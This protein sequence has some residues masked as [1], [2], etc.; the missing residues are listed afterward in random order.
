[1]QF[2]RSLETPV[3]KMVIS[4]QD[5]AIVR[6]TWTEVDAFNDTPLLTETTKQ[7]LA[8]FAGDL[9]EFDLPVSY[10]C[11]AFQ[12]RACEAMRSIPYGTTVTYGELAESMQ[13]AAQPVGNA[14]G[15]NPIPIVVPCHRVLGSTGIGGYSGEGGVE[16]KIA[17]LRLENAI[18]WLI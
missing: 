1:M 2:Q 12:Q 11:S 18:P 14:C 6:L 9:Q 7:L 4:E 13:S 17:L 15:G 8:Y 10:H 3:G 5:G 16:T